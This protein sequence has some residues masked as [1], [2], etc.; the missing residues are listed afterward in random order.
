MKSLITALLIASA[1]SLQANTITPSTLVP[2][3]PGVWIY[4]ANLSSGEIHAGD[5]F[6]IFDFGGYVA[7]SVYAPA[8]WTASATL[9]GSDPAAAPLGVDDP[10]L[11]NLRFTYTGP[12][13]QALG[14]L[15]LGLFGATTTSLAIAVDDWASQDHL[16][17]NPGLVGDGT[18]GTLHRDTII[19]P[20]P[21]AVPDGGSTLALLGLAI[22][23]MAGVKRFHR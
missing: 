8:A 14:A 13:I 16:I 6:T 22:V 3:T 18:L 10:T 7:G 1:L 20:D 19:V 17:G 12:S 2:A 5:S 11:Y 23:G 9:L 15:G 21:V 4:A